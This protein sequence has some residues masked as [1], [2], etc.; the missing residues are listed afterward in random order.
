V[1]RIRGEELTSVDSLNGLLLLGACVVLSGLLGLESG[2]GAV[3][4]EVAVVVHSLLERVSL[5][6]EDVVT[7]SSRATGW[8]VSD[9]FTLL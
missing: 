5:P 9:P 8:G 1:T 7:V 6:A 4:I 3:D 2:L